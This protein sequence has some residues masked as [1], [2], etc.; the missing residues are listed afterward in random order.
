[1]INNKNIQ[2]NF[3]Y[4]HWNIN[5][6]KVDIVQNLGVLSSLIPG[7]TYISGH[8]HLILLKMQR[9]YTDKQLIFN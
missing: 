2:T 4:T 1:M 7:K 6:R 9:N 5:S 8:F 3:N